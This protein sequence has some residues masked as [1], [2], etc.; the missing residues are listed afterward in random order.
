MNFDRIINQIKFLTKS[1]TQLNS[2]I[3]YKIQARHATNRV[4]LGF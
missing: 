3:F 2:H 1:R 4:N